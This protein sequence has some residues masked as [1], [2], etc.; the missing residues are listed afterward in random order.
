MVNSF[1]E[2]KEK[3][4][5]RSTHKEKGMVNAG[6]N[7]DNL[8]VE[9]YEEE[10][11]EE[12]DRFV[13]EHSVNGT[14]LQTR[15]FLNYHPRDRFE[16]ASYI[17][18]DKKGAV[19]AVCPAC[20]RID[21]GKKVLY[22]HMGSTYGGIIISTKWYKT[23]KTMEIVKCLEKKWR[24]DGFYKV[25][26]KQT[27]SLFAVE[28]QDLLEY[29]L[30]YLGYISYKELNLYVDFDGYNEDILSELSRRKR[31]NVYNCDKVGCIC[32]KLTTK[33]DIEKFWHLLELTLQKYERKPIHTV[34]ELFD[35]IINRLKDECEIFGIYK[36]NEMI[37]GS[38]MFYFNRIK[39]A[40][41]QYLCANP[42]YNRLSPMTYTY[43]EMLC[44]MRRRGFD[45][46]SW[47][48]VT[49]DMGRYL[50]E[51]LVDSKEA[52]GSKHAVNITYEKNFND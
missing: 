8:S 12:W 37:A 46:V 27:P 50:N 25:V 15:R 6:M 29:C 14:F 16:D 48:I 52:F 23:N 39:V 22:S 34:E 31:R 10:Y 32:R 2:I 9:I 43:Y 38:M 45:K 24:D 41:T 40:H 11:E 3:F 1:S 33:Q 49:E 51:G 13:T 21:Q 36:D 4:S 20:I 26:L 35:F 44:E 42:E 47:G 28:N 7:N 19:V 5:E 18:R 30:Y 17:V